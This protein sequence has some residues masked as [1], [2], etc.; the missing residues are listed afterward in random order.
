M[1]G[2]EADIQIEK[3]GLKVYF[4][5]LFFLPNWSNMRLVRGELAEQ[6]LLYN[7]AQY[8]CKFFLLEFN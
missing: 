8:F 5:R 3:F 4:M 6:A 2:D 1:H 7:H